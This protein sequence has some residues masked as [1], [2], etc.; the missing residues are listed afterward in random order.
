MVY[1]FY[2]FFNDDNWELS[3]GGDLTAIT[4]DPPPGISAFGSDSN[5]IGFTGIPLAAGTYSYVMDIK[6]VTGAASDTQ[7]ITIA[8]KPTYSMLDMLRKPGRLVAT[9]PPWTTFDSDGGGISMGAVST[10]KVRAEFTLSNVAGN[11]TIGVHA[12]SQSSLAYA[13]RPGCG[14]YTVTAAGTFAVELDAD[15]GA[16]HVRNS[17]G[18]SVASGT[19][20][21][22]Y[23]DD[24]KYRIGY[25]CNG[26]ARIKANFGNEAWAITPTGGFGGLPMPTVEVPAQWDSRDNIDSWMGSVGSKYT[27]AVSAGSLVNPGSDWEV[28]RA[29]FGK[30]SGQWAFAAT[31]PTSMFGNNQRVGIC[32]SAFDA[33]DGHLGAAGTEN[34]IGIRGQSQAEQLPND[35]TLSMDYLLLSWC[36]SGTPGEVRIPFGRGLGAPVKFTFAVDFSTSV[37]RIYGEGE[38]VPRQLLYTLGGLPADTYFPAVTGRSNLGSVLHDSPGIGGFNNWKHTL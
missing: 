32:T 30:S 3:G 24:G 36:F 2:P 8:P 5:S 6:S 11:I 38:G 15:T 16:W 26:T 12:D 14:Y 4:G 9:T 18:T 35:A 31:S 7:S 37:V 28:I 1:L 29:Q 34:S 22:T 27:N 25:Y 17:A 13:G 20:P 21:L 10:G 19:L 23:A 33:A